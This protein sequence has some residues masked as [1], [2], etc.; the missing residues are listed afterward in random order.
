MSARIVLLTAC[1][2][3]ATGCPG[4]VSVATITTP[5]TAEIVSPGSNAQSFAS[6]EVVTFEGVVQDQQDAPDRLTA[7]WASDIDGLLEEAVPDSTGRVSFATVDLSQ[8][9]HVITLQAVDTDGEIGE[10]NVSVQVQRT[11]NEPEVTIDHPLT[12]DSF[13]VGESITFTGIAL[14]PDPEDPPES[15]VVEWA[16]DSDGFLGNDAPNVSGL[17][18]LAVTSLSLGDH[19]VSV[20]VT[21]GMGAT[22]TDQVYLQVVEANEAPQVMIT[23]PMSGDIVLETAIAFAGEVSDDADRADDLAISWES[24]IDGLFNWDNA[25]S[26]GTL[27]FTTS[28]LATGEHTIT[29]TAEDTAGLEA[30]DSMAIT[31]VGEDD[32]DADGDGYT[33]NEGDCDD[34]DAGT[35]PSVIEVCDDIDN[36]C[37][38]EINEDQGDSYEPNDTTAEDLGQMDGDGYC[39]Y[40]VGHVSGSADTQTISANIHAPDDVDLYSFE[41]ED[42]WYD[43]LDES[44]YGIQVSLTSIPSGHDYVLELYWVDGGYSLVASSDASGSSSESVSHEGT[45]GWDSDTDDGGEYEIVVYSN[46]GY[47]CSDSYTLSVE[48]W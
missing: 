21:D 34:D 43:C 8:G 1:A 10:D 44:G 4:D 27:G 47:G 6:G 17:L 2:L 9:L 39:M 32:W 12:G 23:E 33:P 18:S 38:G 26:G 22:A 42:E 20:T 36:D 31:V 16:S 24:S 3:V 45:Y 29:L 7:S 28:S 35:H 5:P 11:N 41:T 37:D 13:V 40:Y 19:I 15:L 14:D 25:S 46:S 48:V 30:S